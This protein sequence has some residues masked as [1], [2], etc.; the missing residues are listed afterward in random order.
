M[1][2]GYS[3]KRRPYWAMMAMSFESGG[4]WSYR[5]SGVGEVVCLISGGT[6]WK[7][8]KALNAVL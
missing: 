5:E 3:L 4:G 8:S 1:E 2:S 6:R 7:V